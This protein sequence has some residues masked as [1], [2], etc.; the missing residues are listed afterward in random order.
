VSNRGLVQSIGILPVPTDNPRS[1]PND[2]TVVPLG[3]QPLLSASKRDILFADVDGD[4]TA[5]PGDIIQYIITLQNLG[6]GTA[7]AV[8]FSDTPDP[9]T[10]LVVGSVTTSQGTI[11]GGNAGTPPVTVS[12]GALPPGQ[13]ATISFQV[14]VNSP[15][16]ASVTEIANQGLFGSSNGGTLPTDDPDTPEPDDPTRTD[17]SQ[18]AGLRI[19][20]TDFGAEVQPGEVVRYTLSFT[21]TG[22]VPLFDVIVRE[23]V[24][25]YTSFDAAGSTPGWS[26][27]DGAPAGTACEIN[28][29][30][31]PGTD[32]TGRGGTGSVV[33]ALRLD[34]NI[35]ENVERIVNIATIGTASRPASGN[36][37]QASDTTPIVRPTFVVLTSFTTRYDYAARGIA[38]SWETALE[39]DSW[40]FHLWRSANGRRENA[41]R[42]TPTII[43]ARGGPYSGASYS[44]L[45][46]TARPGLSYSYWLEE[47]EIGGGRYEYGP[48][49]F[50]WGYQR[51]GEIDP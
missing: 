46:R 18:A 32:G 36:D 30:A 13:M 48:T 44:F 26:C 5:S 7:S 1:D 29:G 24:P 49:R 25:Q 33:F 6:A 51:P 41:T 21:N 3:P 23:T 2:P 31:L 17:I 43:P 9:N 38:V 8:T 14:R 4:G 35:P 39:L 47:I 11:T 15:L 27:A 19:S 42:V 37:P 22:V 28:V 10:T 16:P 50:V 20:K 45:D 40:G 12:L 34:Q